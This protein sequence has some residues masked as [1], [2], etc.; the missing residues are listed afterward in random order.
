M[1]K[2]AALRRVNILGVGVHAI[3][4]RQALE[5]VCSAI[6]DGRKGYV[7]VTGVHGIMEAQTDSQFRSILNGSFITMP[8]GMP[9]V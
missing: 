3:D 4:M 8:D 5:Q 1:L 6:E 7:C 9:T 2:Q